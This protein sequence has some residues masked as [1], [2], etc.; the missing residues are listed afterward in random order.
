MIKFIATLLL[1]IVPH[2][3]FVIHEVDHLEINSA[4]KDHGTVFTQYLFL[5]VGGP[6]EIMQW[7]MTTGDIEKQLEHQQQGIFYITTN[8]MQKNGYYV[9]FINVRGVV[10]RSRT[11]GDPEIERQKEQPLLFRPTHIKTR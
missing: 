8:V 1:S 3:P 9:L 10:A 5:R 6:E 4:I 11:Y 7:C 2:D